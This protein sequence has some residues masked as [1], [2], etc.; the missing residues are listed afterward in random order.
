MNRLRL[1]TAA[2]VISSLVTTPAISQPTKPT[3]RL[4]KDDVCWANVTD[5]ASKKW[6]LKKGT[7]V[8]FV[9]DQGSYTRVKMADGD[10]CS[11]ASDSIERI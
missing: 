7:E 4:I 2:G 3:H 11:I 10:D 6:E 9:Y 5:G 8:T 1:L